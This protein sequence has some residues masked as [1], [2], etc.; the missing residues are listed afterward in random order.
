MR[1]TRQLL[2]TA[3]A[4]VALLAATGCGGERVYPVQGKITF[5]GKPLQ[6]GGAISFVPLG[7][8]EGKTAGGEIAEDGTYKL[9]TH[10]PDDGSMPGEFRVVVMQ[11]V[12]REPV[13]KRDG[14]KAAQA[15]AAVPKED[16][17]PEIY[18]DFQKSPLT[19]KVEAKDNRID[20]DLKRDVGAA[21][22]ARGGAR[23]GPRGLDVA[24]L[25]RDPF[26]LFAP[27]EPR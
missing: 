23:A 4:A 22:P 5:E 1:A 14:E 6:G 8:Q 7:K 26:G 20:F 18:G 10:K 3:G 21:A 15:V 25:D 17:I 9:T 11:V 13:K 2:Q 19:A 27:R 12:E 16:R 24:R